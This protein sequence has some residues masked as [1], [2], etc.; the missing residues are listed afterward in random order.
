M[1]T[2]TAPK[3]IKS[4]YFVMEAGNWHLKPGVPKEVVEEFE[5]YMEDHKKW[6]SQ[7]HRE[8]ED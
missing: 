4:P 7:F 5:E 1:S 8:K 6:A 2:G 3:F